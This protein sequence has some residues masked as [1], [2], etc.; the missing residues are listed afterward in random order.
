MTAQQLKNCRESIKPTIQFH[1]SNIRAILYAQCST[2]TESACEKRN[3]NLL[4][5]ELEKYSKKA[6]ALENAPDGD[7]KPYPSLKIY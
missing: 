1:L 7:Q 6:E 2:W 4:F 3:F 5:S